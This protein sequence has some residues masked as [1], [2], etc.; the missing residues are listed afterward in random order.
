MD[1]IKQ[2]ALFLNNEPVQ[3]TQQEI[4]IWDM[5]KVDLWEGWYFTDKIKSLPALKP[6]IVAFHKPKNFTV[7]KDDKF[8]KT[9]YS[10][11]PASWRKDFY[12]IGRLDKDSHWLL[13]LT[14]DTTLVDF[15]E[16]PVNRIFK[17]YEVKISPR[18][19][20]KHIQKLKKWIYADEQWNIASTETWELLNFHDVQKIADNPKNSILRIVLKEGKNRHI[21]RWLKALWYRVLDLKRIKVWKYELWD[22]KPGKYRIYKV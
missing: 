19:K 17:I 12:Y 6:V 10:L 4:I 16:N 2:G 14:N 7:S 8:N 3:S 20:T 5:I 21:R 11:L 1:M 9:I 13:L 18:F 15:Y 22:I